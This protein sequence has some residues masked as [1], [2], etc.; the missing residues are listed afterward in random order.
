MRIL[1]AGASGLIG[2]ALCRRLSGHGHDV[3]RLV[4]REPTATDERNW[5][6]ESGIIDPAAMDGVDA[7]VNLSGAS[8]SRLPWT[9]RYRAEILRSRVTAT[10][11][12]ADAMVA[13]SRPPAV[14]VSGSAVGIYGD[15]PGLVLDEDSLRGSGFLADVVDAWEKA[16][17]LVPEG[18]RVVTVRTGLV[19][20]RGGGA[21]KP[22][23]PLT[24]IGAGGP[25]GPGTQYWPWISLADEVAAIEHLLEAD[26][27][28]PVNLAGPVPATSDELLRSVARHMHRPYVLRVPAR[29]IELTLGDAGR[30]L[31]LAS[32]KVSA[33][34]LIDSGFGFTHRTVDE[35]V[36]ELFR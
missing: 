28:G 12:L 31:L 5:S 8:L 10:R 17:A 25:L 26:V 29:L 2:T 21:L 15:R 11:T 16:A 30:E 20:A 36:S 9:R 33:Q 32:Q 23:I 19:V 3:V 4:R 34:R 24:R 27:A 22:V 13:S 14:F 1:I 35:A 6:P 18:V 7:V